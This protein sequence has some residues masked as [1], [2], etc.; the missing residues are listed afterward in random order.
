MN[1]FGTDVGHLEEADVRIIQALADIAT[2]GTEAGRLLDALAP[3][4]PR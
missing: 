4:M 2:I 3:A 1:L